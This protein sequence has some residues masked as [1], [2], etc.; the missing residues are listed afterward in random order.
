[1]NKT[2]GRRLRKIAERYTN[3]LAEGDVEGFRRAWDERVR[4]WLHEIQRRAKLH[5]RSEEP[6]SLIKDRRVT[7]RNV[8]VEIFEIL[9]ASNRLLLACGDVVDGL[10][11]EETRVTLWNEC[12]K[13]VAS[14]YDKRLYQPVTKR[15]YSGSG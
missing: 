11:G 13:A 8:K 2:S 10:V 6:N 15:R 12:A 5:R 4:G 14:V 3:L 9:D 1:M 7:R